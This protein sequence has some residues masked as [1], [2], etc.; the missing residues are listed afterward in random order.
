MRKSYLS[1]LTII[2]LNSLSAQDKSFTMTT[3]MDT[4]LLGNYIEVTFTIENIQGKFVEP[5]FNGMELISGPNTFTSTAIKNGE[6]KSKSTYSYILKPEQ[7]GIYLI[8]SSKLETKE[9][10]LKTEEKKIVVQDNPD[11]IIQTPAQNNESPYDILV[12]PGQSKP[13]SKKK[14]IKL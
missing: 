2:L 8:E 12:K 1:I 11:K 4:I 6:V 7:V 14:I 10:V 13:V 3:S 9:G 5:N